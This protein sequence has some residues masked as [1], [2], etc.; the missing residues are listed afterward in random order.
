MKKTILLIVLFILSACAIKPDTPIPSINPVIFEK[1]GGEISV[2]MSA[3]FMLVYDKDKG[4]KYTDH[5]DYDGVFNHRELDCGWVI[6][7]S[8]RRD[9][10]EDLL[11]II[12][13]P[14]TT[15]QERSLTMKLQER[16][17]GKES[18]ISS[19]TVIQKGE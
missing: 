11:F 8:Y 5:Y 19:I 14:N 12:T 9:I 17:N 15:G 1:E 7:K 10:V 2:P 13:E 18:G 6:L 3:S 4:Y 16:F